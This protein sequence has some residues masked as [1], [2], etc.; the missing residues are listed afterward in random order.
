M[1]IEG[2]RGGEGPRRWCAVM[3]TRSIVGEAEERG[4]CEWPKQAEEVCAGEGS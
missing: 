2:V 3:E 4:A 1:T